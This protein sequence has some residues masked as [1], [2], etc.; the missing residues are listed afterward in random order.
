MESDATRGHWDTEL[1][2]LRPCKALDTAPKP[3]PTQ[4]TP[5]TGRASAEA[6]Y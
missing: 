1:E 4:W 6:P 2:A 5:N 3:V